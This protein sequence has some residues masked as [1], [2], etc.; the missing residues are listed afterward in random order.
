[1]ATL[2]P[3]LSAVA[4][5]TSSKATLRIGTRAVTAVERFG[6]GD[7]YAEVILEPGGHLPYAKKHL[8]EL[9]FGDL[10]AQVALDAHP[11]LFRWI[12]EAWVGNAGKEKV[13]LDTVDSAGGPVRSIELALARVREVT[14]PALDSTSH[15]R[16]FLGLS[17]APRGVRRLKGTSPPALAKEP[18]PFLA[19][20]F[21]VEIDGLDCSGVLAVD[22]VTVRTQLP[23][24]T[25][26]ERPTL[27]FPDLHLHVEA[28]KAE[29]FYE[30]FEDFVIRGNNDDDHEK[31]CTIGYLEPMLSGPLAELKVHHLGICR[32]T[33]EPT[34]TGPKRVRV[35]LYCER[36]EL[37]GRSA[38]ASETVET[39]P[40][41]L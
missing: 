15:E 38:P 39:A 25:G 31:A 2:P 29:P 27:V 5:A 41:R 23:D 11:A 6:G 36:M 34:A 37:V 33:D 18:R 35:D 32:I 22:P 8:G 9:R 26:G 12:S 40:V 10:D 20:N 3:R 30:W 24:E 14:L 7:P 28:E 1:M 4:R 17:I 21:L 16:R 13:A 19:P